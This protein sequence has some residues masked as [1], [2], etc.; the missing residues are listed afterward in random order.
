MIDFE[1][2]NKKSF[3]NIREKLL[4]VLNSADEFTNPKI[5]S[6]PRSIGDLVQAFIGESL[7]NLLPQ[8][9]IKDYKSDFP[10]RALQDIAFYDQKDNYYIIDVKTHN[11]STDFNMPN[12]ISVKRLSELYRNDKNVFIILLAEY[13]EKDGRA[14]FEDVKFAPIENFSWTCLTLGALGWGQIQIS[15]ANKIVIDYNIARKTWMLNLFEKMKSFY[16]KEI[17]KLKNRMSYFVQMKKFWDE[18]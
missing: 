10:R 11:K 3:E 17:A 12:L 14:Y 13:V 5:I 18:K 1:I 7:P 15:N 16:P 6:S 4:E 9:S 8:G 2:I